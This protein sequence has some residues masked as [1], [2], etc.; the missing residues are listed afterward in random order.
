MRMKKI[1]SL[2]CAREKKEVASDWRVEKEKKRGNS[3]LAFIRNFETG[4]QDGGKE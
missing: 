2:T 3:S 4:L 1:F